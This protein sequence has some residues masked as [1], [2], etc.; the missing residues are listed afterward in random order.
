MRY[1]IA[2]IFNE[3]YPEESIRFSYNV[4]RSIFC[5][6]LGNFHIE[7]RI[8]DQVAN[9]LEKSW[10]PTFRLKRGNRFDGEAIQIYQN[11]ICTIKSI[12]SN[13][14]PKRMSIYTVAVIISIIFTVIWFLPPV[15]CKTLFCALT[16]GI[17]IQYPRYE[18]NGQ[19]PP[20]EEAPTYGRTLKRAYEWAEVI[21]AQTIYR[22]NE[23]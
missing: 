14:V 21:D 22:I 23:N 12:F 10:M 7:R 2:M 5:Q 13:T 18:L 20:F 19:I 16:A 8:V 3:L 15:I 1:V 4:S 6:P 11:S 9:R 17:I